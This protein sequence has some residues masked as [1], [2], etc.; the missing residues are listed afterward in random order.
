M[1]DRIKQVATEES[2][3]VKDMTTDAIKS[4]AYLY[5]LKVLTRSNATVWFGL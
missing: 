1:A 3:K 2:K 4:R 5:P